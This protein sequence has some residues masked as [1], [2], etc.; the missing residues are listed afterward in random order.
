MDAFARHRTRILRRRNGRVFSSKFY[1]RGP[2][3]IVLINVYHL[4]VVLG[5]QEI[6]LFLDP[7][8]R[9][10]DGKLERLP[11]LRWSL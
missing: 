2:R 3:R 10:A 6:E 5:L 7:V 11:R 9:L 8:A 4:R 1:A